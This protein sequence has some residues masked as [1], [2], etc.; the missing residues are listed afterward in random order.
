M[1]RNTFFLS[2]M[3]L[4]FISLL[5]LGGTTLL[6]A[7]FFPQIQDFALD[8]LKKNHLSLKQLG[9]LLIALASLI[10]ALFYRLQRRQY[11]IINMGN[12]QVSISE[13]A[14]TKT[15]TPYWKQ[16]F[17]D[18]ELIF[19]VKIPKNVVEISVDFPPIPHTHEK[20]LLK[21]VE[22]DLENILADFMDYRKE[23][24]LIVRF[25]EEKIQG[26]PPLPQETQ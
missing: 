10:F 25:A 19:Q 23:F 21:R 6:F 8:F 9:A 5:F 14:I 26:P 3:N 18:K 22:K 11:Y 2:V 15:L 1:N 24:S 7:E 13:Q 20:P 12:R 16:L 17:P 4:F